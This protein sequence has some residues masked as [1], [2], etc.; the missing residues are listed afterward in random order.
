MAVTLDETVYCD[1]S[2]VTFNITDLNGPV[3]GDKIFTLTTTYTSG[4]VA[5]VSQNG[6]Y[7]RVDLTDNCKTSAIACRLLPINSDQGLKTRG[8]RVPAI[9]A[10]VMISVSQYI[11]ILPLL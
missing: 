6:D 8:G 5:G 4:M 2:A 9:A 1:L 11:L 7:E 3:I 10:K